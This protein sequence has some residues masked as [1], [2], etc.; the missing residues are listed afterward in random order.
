MR[1]QRSGDSPQPTHWRDRNPKSGDERSGD[2]VRVM[3][4][5]DYACNRITWRIGTCWAGLLTGSIQL[6]AD[7]TGSYWL[8]D[9]LCL[10]LVLADRL[11][12]APSQALQPLPSWAPLS[13][14]QASS[15]EE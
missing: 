3:R 6:L 4:T 14:S 13:L 7:L 15:Q 11:L 5:P 12:L 8:T 2:S 1:I 9:P 10:G